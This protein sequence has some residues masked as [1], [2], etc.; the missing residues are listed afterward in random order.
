MKK[1]M[2]ILI[3]AFTYLQ[4]YACITLSNTIK[5]EELQKILF[6]MQKI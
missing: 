2:F 5:K 4:G 6:T 3:L 1:L